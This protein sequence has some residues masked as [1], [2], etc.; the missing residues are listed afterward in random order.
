MRDRYLQIEKKRNIKNQA[1]N[2]IFEEAFDF[3]LEQFP[4]EKKD[5]PGFKLK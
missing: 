5:T 1:L 2:G 3:I 4:P